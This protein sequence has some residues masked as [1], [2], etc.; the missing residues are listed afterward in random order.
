MGELFPAIVGFGGIGQ[1][2][3]DDAWVCQCILVFR[4]HLWF[5]ANDTCIGIREQARCK[6]SNGQVGIED[7]TPFATKQ[8]LEFSSDGHFEPRM[9]QRPPGHVVDDPIE[10]LVPRRAR[11][12]EGDEIRVSHVWLGRDA[13]GHA[14]TVARRHRRVQEQIDVFYRIGAVDSSSKWNKAFCVSRRKLS[15]TVEVFRNAAQ[16]QWL[17]LCCW[18]LCA[19]ISCVQ[20][21]R[22]CLD[23]RVK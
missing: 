16:R 13:A 14:T 21:V 20:H 3:H 15:G 2:F 9:C 10:P 7:P 1:D 6:D 8:V 19:Y 4:V 11:R 22:I 18:R 17:E 23:E 12:F 5:G